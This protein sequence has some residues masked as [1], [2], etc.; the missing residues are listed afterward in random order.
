MHTNAVRAWKKKKEA[1]QAQDEGKWGRRRRELYPACFK[2]VF[3]AVKFLI[4]PRQ[5]RLHTG[6]TVCLLS[7]S[8]QGG[9]AGAG[10]GQAGI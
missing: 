10:G 1:H 3:K 8:V 7:C 9:G 5:C 6:P 4:Q 2:D